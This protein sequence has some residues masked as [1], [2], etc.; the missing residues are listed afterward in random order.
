M[1]LLLPILVVLSAAEPDPTAAPS[2][3]AATPLT[4]VQLKLGGMDDDERARLLRY[5]DDLLG[6]ANDD[7]TMR[8]LEQRLTA[9]PRYRKASCRAQG[10]VA[11]CDVLRARVLHQVRVQGLPVAIL[12]SDLR[13]R[14][15]LKPGEAI[16]GEDDP[17][18]KS[19]LQRQ[20]ARILDFL[21]RE[22]Y[23]GADVRLLLPRV[24]AKGEH[25]VVIRVRGGSFVRV[26]KVELAS[27]GP[28]SQL[29]LQAAF[30]H[31]CLTSEGF[32]DGIVV[33]NLLS[34][35]NRRRLQA[36]IDELTVELRDLDYPEGR[37]RVDTLP[38]DPATTDDMD[39]AQTPLTVS[40]ALDRGLQPEPR[41]VDLR[42]HVDAGPRLTARVHVA[43][44]DRPLV[45]TPPLLPDSFLWVRETFY[46]PLVRGLQLLVN[47]PLDQAPD[48]EVV[49]QRFL[50][51]L[52]FE[53]A[54]SVDQIE[55]EL[56]AEAAAA[57]L[58][59]R[60]RVDPSVRVESSSFAD[61]RVLDFFAE[62]TSVAAVGRVRIDGNV[63]LDDDDLLALAEVATQPRSW[64]QPGVLSNAQLRDDE[65][66]LRDAYAGLGFP[67]ATVEAAATMV[68]GGRI[69][70]VFHVVEGARFV[71]S[72]VE[73][74]GGDP[75]L[76]EDVLR[77]MVHCEGGRATE[78]KRAPR[79]PGD[80]VG[81][82][83]RTN[84][85]DADQQ[86][87]QTVYASHGY[88]NADVTVE[89]AFFADGA[90]L[91]VSVVPFDATSEARAAP[92]P[93][94][95]RRVALGEV[96]LEGNY[97]TDRAVLLR[98]AGIDDM[99]HGPLDPI[100]LGKGIS[101]LRRTG[102]FD[103]V[104]LEYL[105][106]EQGAERAHVRLTVEER[107]A[108][109]VDTSLG[110]STQQLASWRA[111]A[112]HR[113]LFGTMLD[114]SVLMDFGLF[115]GRFSQARGT[116]R[117]PR[118]LGSDVTVSYTPF[119]VSYTDQPAGARLPIPSTAAGQK[120]TATWEAPDFR[121][122]LFSVGTS[123]AAEW[124][125]H[126]LWEPID[127]HLGVGVVLD[128]RSE[129]LDP[130]GRYVVPFTMDAL[131]TVDGL[132]EVLAV[133]SALSAS[134]TPRVSYNAV[135]NPFDPRGGFSAELFVRTAPPVPTIAY[136]VVGAQLRG[137]HTFFE[138][139]TIAGS[140]RT[141]AGLS[142]DPSAYCAEGGCEWAVM[143]SDLFLLGGE[144]SV[145][146]VLENQ[147]G[148]LGPIYDANLC[149]VTTGGERVC[150]PDPD[151]AV[152]PQVQL[153]P[154]RLGAVIN[155]E[156]RYTLLRD[157]LIGDVRPAVFY[158][159]GMSSDDLQ[160]K[161]VQQRDDPVDVRYAYS[162]G[163]GVRWVT[164]VGPISIDAAYSPQRNT[165][166][167]YGLLGYIF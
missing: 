87:V 88:P 152:E 93:G 1:S 72:G 82:P 118:L 86:R 166:Q 90:R 41:C 119:A 167:V 117:W 80:C 136:A 135:D 47:A 22:G 157:F 107:P 36:T 158:D 40:K 137:Y 102:L 84:E 31:M 96:F 162:V 128:L 35:Y 153:H 23:R 68:P 130:A 39:C 159:F 150:Q 53:Q 122:R 100:E 66:R 81:A 151:V 112:R 109:T 94:N 4:D 106:L 129:W 9:L 64:Q 138:R 30:G 164:P 97:R 18:G 79:V 46:E 2:A 58:A 165:A 103:G 19:R 43:A 85:L 67:E 127:D 132:T 160:L 59:R 163:A 44:G 115:I 55:V 99:A 57:Y 20:R 77:A 42:V 7:A 104:Q 101:R 105:G 61:E 52:S 3:P 12:E 11:R 21:E 145:R 83:L 65:A 71:L 116:L 155:L 25:D 56:T 62:G 126:E 146:G 49:E 154:G 140:L 69:D 16:E 33:G 5:L 60:G 108:L 124:R 111:E 143:Q 141:R 73:L 149:V 156:V 121:R 29:R 24:N 10:E 26:R 32:L 144:R 50:E 6:Q 51:A 70:V 113:N 110:F 120:A 48:T 74:A 134:L 98:E 161:L 37:I 63:T 92:K 142:S 75:A 125:P 8:R 45:E 76:T 139:L 95:L 133:D 78:E 114:A 131:Q 147:I 123:L 148:V 91:R 34:C 89:T 13:K 14:V 15:F 27:W 38:V 17:T 28:L 54:G